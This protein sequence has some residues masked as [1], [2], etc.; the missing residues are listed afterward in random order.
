MFTKGFQ[1]RFIF[2]SLYTLEAVELD[3]IDSTPTSSV[4]KTLVIDVNSSNN[5][6]ISPKIYQK[7][8]P[9]GASYRRKIDLIPKSDASPS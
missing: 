8:D 4:R 9:S 6:I 1:Q 5:G 3:H 7:A 2:C